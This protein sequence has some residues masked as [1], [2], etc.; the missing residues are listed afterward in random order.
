MRGMLNRISLV[1]LPQRRFSGAPAPEAEGDPKPDEKQDAA[2][3]TYDVW[4]AALS[5]DQKRLVDG[6]TASLKSALKTERTDRQ[7]VERDLRDAAAKL[8]KGSEAEKSLTEAADAAA[9][10]NQRADFY[11]EASKPEHRVAN[12]KAL[13]TLATANGHIDEKGRIDWTTLK[14]DYPQL[15]TQEAPKPKAAGNAGSGTSKEIKSKT[16]MNSFIRGGG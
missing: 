10:A 5:D 9:R 6:N 11:E 15:F 14:A 4:Y 3:L 16:D 2:P 13:Y 1:Q 8:E 12:A 7:K